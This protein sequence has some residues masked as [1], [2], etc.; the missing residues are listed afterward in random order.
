MVEKK[1]TQTFKLLKE[2]ADLQGYE[3]VR[4]TNNEPTRWIIKEEWEEKFKEMDMFDI[5]KEIKIID[6]DIQKRKEFKSMVNKDAV[7][8]L[9][10]MTNHPEANFLLKV[11]GV[12][13]KHTI[14]KNECLVIK[15]ETSEDLFN[16]K[17]YL[18]H[19]LGQEKTNK[20]HEEL[21]LRIDGTLEV[22]EETGVTGRKLIITI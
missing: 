6:T 15:D 4:K 11:G 1:Q 14:V 12:G 8:F 9:K 10:T 13:G 3:L 5:E 22:H 20:F 16:L 7:E 17:Q 2:L 18:N 19:I 21:K